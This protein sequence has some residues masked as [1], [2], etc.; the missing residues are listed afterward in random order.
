MNTQVY[1]HRLRR[2]YDRYLEEYFKSRGPAEFDSPEK[3]LGW[4][5]VRAMYELQQAAE[6]PNRPGH[7]WAKRIISRQHHRDVFTMEESDGAI[8]LRKVERVLREIRQEFP[9]RDFIADL[10][11]KTVAI[12]KLALEDDQ[13]DRGL[14]DFPVVD[15]GRR[16]SL[17]GRSYVLRKLPREFRVGFIFADV[18]DKT[19][20][21]AIRSR[22]REIRNRQ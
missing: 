17:G 10:P 8:V 11:E 6:D 3:I 21:D 16:D 15:G 1:Y 9:D 2:I 18:T 20:R 12:H 7:A 5:D 4:N 13:M 14:I 19:E 22:C